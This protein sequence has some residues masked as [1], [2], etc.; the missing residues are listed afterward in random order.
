MN[1]LLLITLAL[2]LIGCSEKKTI[3]PVYDFEQIKEAKKLTAITVSSSTSYFMYKDEPMGYEYDLIK[4]FCDNHGLNLEIKVAENTPRLIEMLLN[5]EGD[6]VITPI[7]VQNSLKDSLIYCGQEYISHQV[8]IQ[9]NDVKDSLITD[10]TQLIGKNIFVKPDTKYYQRLLN[11]NTELGGGILI[12]DVEKDTITVEDLIEMVS[13]HHIDYTIAEDYIAK[14]NKTYYNNIDISLAVSFEQRSSWVVRKDEPLLAQAINEWFADNSKK[15]TFASAIKKYFE[16]S[17]KNIDETSEPT[18]AKVGDLSPY[19]AIFKKYEKVSGYDWYLLAA[20][21]YQE[22]RFRNNLTSWA[23][24]TGLMG[25]MPRTARSLGVADDQLNDPDSNIMAGANLIKRLNA[26]FTKIKDPHQKIKF[27]L[28]SYNAG[29][30]HVSDAQALARK[31]G[32]DPYIWDDSVEKYIALKSNP[33]Y[34]NDSVCRNGYLRSQ[35]VLAY[36][37]DVL[38]NWEK[39]RNLN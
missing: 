39:F 6:I 28:A 36:V 15:Q 18:I 32:D 27:V 24:A 16:L 14:L 9:R 35:E 34:Y 38:T 12:N 21:C 26:I 3:A 8:L 31:Y 10:V 29:N 17:K 1:R 20:I 33:E 37:G 11:L 4:D 7:A 2:L 22:S 13:L 19:D 25:L 23:G 30:G 5:H